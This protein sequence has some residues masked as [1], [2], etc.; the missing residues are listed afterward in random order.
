MP[1][2]LEKHVVGHMTKGIEEEA[3]KSRRRGVGGGV[4]VCVRG[5]AGGEKKRTCP[6]GCR[7]IYIPI[8]SDSPRAWRSIWQITEPDS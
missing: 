5:L 7:P 3:S 4:G 1:H 2:I 6:G 8:L